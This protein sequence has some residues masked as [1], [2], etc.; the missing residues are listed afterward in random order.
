MVVYVDNGKPVS[1]FQVLKRKGTH[2]VFYRKILL[3]KKSASFKERVLVGN[4][5]LWK[6][7]VFF[8]EKYFNV[9]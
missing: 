5:H 8:P 9:I 6:V 7:F 2:S 1:V 4:L 3:G